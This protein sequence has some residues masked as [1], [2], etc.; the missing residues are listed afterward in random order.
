MN[1]TIYFQR[2]EGL[3]IFGLSLYL[4]VSN[5]F[6]ILGFIILLIAIDLSMAGYI[7]NKKTG[8]LIYNIG[9]SLITPIVLFIA[10]LVFGGGVF[11]AL[12]LIWIAHVGI[13][14]AL[15][16]G[17]KSSEGFGHTHLGKIGKAKK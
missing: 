15:G 12:A 17:L 13:D 11:L 7:V 8:A 14:R 4:Y 10:Y 9:H 2:L 5:H 1:Q 6:N 16:L 3:A